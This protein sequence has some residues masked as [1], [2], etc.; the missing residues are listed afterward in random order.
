MRNIEERFWKKVDKKSPDECWEWTASTNEKGYGIIGRGRRG[1]G[2]VKAH[3]LSYELANGKIDD[4]MVIC[5]SCDNPK[6]VN[7]NHLFLG[8]NGDNVADMVN[9]NRNVNGEQVG[10]SKL[11][12]YQVI[13]IKNIYSTGKYSYRQIAEMYNVSRSL[14][15]YIVRGEK[16]AHLS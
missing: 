9:K 6:C 2:T 7:P 14:I 12:E 3:R 1:E 11:S 16:W 4:N 10:T 5:H 8:T 15:G 13:E